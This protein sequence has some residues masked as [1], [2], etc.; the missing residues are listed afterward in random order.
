MRECIARTLSLEHI[1]D[2]IALVAVLEIM[3]GCQ[4]QLWRISLSGSRVIVATQLRPS[5]ALEDG[6]IPTIDAFAVYVRSH[7][8]YSATYRRVVQWVIVGKAYSVT[9]PTEQHDESGC[10]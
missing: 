5:R 3:T 8:I 6:L 1:I 10:S 7:R 2:L 9:G 4:D